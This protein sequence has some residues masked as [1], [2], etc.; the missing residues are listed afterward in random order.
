MSD[1]FDR[2]SSHVDLP[3]RLVTAA[4]ELTVESM[5]DL[6]D[7]FDDYVSMLGD[8]KVTTLLRS[9]IDAS[10]EGDDRVVGLFETTHM[11]SDK[12]VVPKFYSKIW[13]QRIDSVLKATCIRNTTKDERWPIIT[14]K[15]DS[16]AWPP[17]E[18]LR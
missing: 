2:Y 4:A 9:V 8:L 15:V 14:H 17:K 1:Q 10:F 5:D 3:F 12:I 7:G 16:A 6:H 13:I 18:T 11:S